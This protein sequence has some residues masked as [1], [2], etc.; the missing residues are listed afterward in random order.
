M[1]AG[2]ALLLG[3]APPTY[4]TVGTLEV[5]EAP[6]KEIGGERPCSNPYDGAKGSNVGS[7]FEQFRIMSKV[8]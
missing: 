2:R 3:W 7:G 6:A 4:P 5:D 1:D 8:H